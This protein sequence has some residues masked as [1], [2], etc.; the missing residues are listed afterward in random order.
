MTGLSGTDDDDILLT[1][2]QVIFMH[3]FVGSNIFRTK[4][5]GGTKYVLRSYISEDL[6]FLKTYYFLGPNIFR[7][8][9][10]FGTK[11]IF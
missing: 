11:Y 2:L 5:F 1:Y 7:D 6:I 10:I 8:L 3:F 9:I 4:Y